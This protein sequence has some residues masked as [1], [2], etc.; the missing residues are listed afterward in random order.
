MFWCMALSNPPRMRAQSLTL[1]SWAGVI[2]SP[3]LGHKSTIGAAQTMAATAA[4][5]P[6]PNCNLAVSPSAADGTQGNKQNLTLPD[7]S[8]TQLIATTV[9]VLCHSVFMAHN[10]RPSPMVHILQ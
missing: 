4:F 7:G 6:L 3:T 10:S 1:I 5:A 9:S 8:I 2:G